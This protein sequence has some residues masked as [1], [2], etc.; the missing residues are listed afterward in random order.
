[1]NFLDKWELK[2]SELLSKTLKVIKSLLKFIKL[3]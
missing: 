3:L 1:M 2:L